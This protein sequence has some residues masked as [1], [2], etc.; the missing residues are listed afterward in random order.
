M[1][2]LESRI[3]IHDS[4]YDKVP[5]LEVRALVRHTVRVEDSRPYNPHTS[6]S[7]NDR[8]TVESEYIKITNLS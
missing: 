1:S 5:W 2:F 7:K 4:R 8:L 6:A 3:E